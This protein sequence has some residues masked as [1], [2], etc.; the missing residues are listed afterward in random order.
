MTMATDHGPK[1]LAL[2]HFVPVLG[3]WLG[4]IRG[5]GGYSHIKLYRYVRSLKDTGFKKS[6]ECEWGQGV[7]D[8]NL[9]SE[10]VYGI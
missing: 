8:C 10:I 1:A 9:W 2:H 6:K 7:T 4:E 3:R 5:G